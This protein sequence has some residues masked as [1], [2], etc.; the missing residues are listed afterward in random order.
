MTEDHPI[1]KAIDLGG[2]QVCDIFIDLC[3]AARWVFIKR[4]F[5][6]GFVSGWCSAL[7]L[8]LLFVMLFLQH[9]S[10]LTR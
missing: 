10:L 6:F 9:Q 5:L 8:N 2:G 4:R 1:W 3:T 7:V